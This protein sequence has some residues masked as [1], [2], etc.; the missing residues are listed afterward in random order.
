MSTLDVGSPDNVLH[1]DGAGRLNISSAWIWFLPL[2]ASLL[3]A[4][5]KGMIRDLSQQ[6][7]QALMVS[8]V[9][10]VVLVL[11]EKALPPAGP[12][13]RSPHIILNLQIGILLLFGVTS[14]GAFDGFLVSL[15]RRH[16]SVRQV[17]LSLHSADTVAALVVT[18]LF[19]WLIYDF[20]Y[21]WYHRSQHTFSVLWQLHKFHHLD[22]QVSVTTRFR[23]QLTD[24]L[25]NSLLI[26][27]S[28]ALIFRLDPIATAK[29]STFIAL[30][31]EFLA[32]YKHLNIRLHLGWA[33]PLMVGPQTHRIH[34]SRLMQHHNR[35]F[36]VYFMIWD[37][38]FGTYYH[39]SRAEFP[40]TGVDGESD[41][42][43]VHEVLTL[44]YRGW[45]AMFGDWRHRPT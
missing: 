40:P 23:A 8:L 42:R 34:H 26:G 9:M 32:D 10:T 17:D 2:G 28:I 43:S 37:I 12:H 16:L 11:V 24:V 6:Y 29:Y 5:A 44:P 14:F 3:A 45:W 33:S 15:L 27:T 36:G 18:V 38:L 13:K 4:T 31:G 35:N 22:E 39:P 21:Y 20:F 30:A 41:V 1:R 19:S 25:I 7:L